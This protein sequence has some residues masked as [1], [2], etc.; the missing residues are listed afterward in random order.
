[1]SP[2]RAPVLALLLAACAPGRLHLEPV[3][4]APTG[5][6]QAPLAVFVGY[7][8]DARPPGERQD[9]AWVYT[10]PLPTLYYG[11]LNLRPGS[12][13]LVDRTLRDALRAAGASVVDRPEEADL[14]V[15]PWVLHHAGRRDI[16]DAHVVNLLTAG[17]AGRVGEFLYPAFVTVEVHVRVE[18]LAPEDDGLRLL[19]VRDIEAFAL[20]RRALGRLRGLYYG[21]QRSPTKE[22]FA[23]A[24]H[25]VHGEIGVG[26]ANLVVGIAQGEQTGAPPDDPGQHYLKARWED[27]PESF[28]LEGTTGERDPL[29][30]AKYP[31]PRFS[32]LT[33]THLAKGETLGRIG[34]PFDTLGY[35][36]GVAD[37]IQVLA[38]ITL[39]G[40]PRLDE[41]AETIGIGPLDAARA[42][43]EGDLVGL[44]NAA[45]G[46][47]RFQVLEGPDWAVSVEGRGGAQVVLLAD[48]EFR[49]QV[50]GL[51]ARG[52]LI[53]SWSPGALTWFARGGARH[54][55]RLARF[56]EEPLVPGA[57]LIGGAGA[58]VQLSNTVA[59]AFE[60][61]GEAPLDRRARGTV[62]PQLTLGLR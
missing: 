19:A 22:L 3:A 59:G 26:V 53:G 58:E 24:F 36:V 60:L 5:G 35:E 21:F 46:G 25:E 27:T 45:S 13:D 2:A 49:P 38:D 44:Y 6:S 15:Q 34:F 43:L 50:A 32:P 16:A 18:V 39:L 12:M 54:G 9:G 23:E 57:R 48:Q 29:L 14:V 51:T 42:Y 17:T 61:V 10:N 31:S 47:L 20:R 1:M 11:D 56:E 40:L 55:V 33:G 8:A 4:F 37:R 62:Y 52:A 7:P 28:F 30:A 41:D